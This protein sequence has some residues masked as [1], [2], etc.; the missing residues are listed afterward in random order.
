ML[1]SIVFCIAHNREAANAL[2]SVYA[3]WT[4]KEEF[5]GHH[6]NCQQNAS[7]LEGKPSSRADVAIVEAHIS[8]TGDGA[9]FNCRPPGG[10]ADLFL[11]QL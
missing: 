3:S 2:C 1:M 8:G 9:N 5:S 6:E 4:R 10:G 11:E 7:D